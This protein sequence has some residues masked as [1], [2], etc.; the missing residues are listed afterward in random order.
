M[1]NVL[2]IVHLIL[3]LFLIG[4]VLLQRSEGGALGIG[5]GGGG[6]VGASRGGTTALAKVTWTLAA[7]FIATSLALTIIAAQ[8]GA[9][10]S[11]IDRVDPAADAPAPIAPPAAEDD[12]VPADLRDLLAPAPIPPAEPEGDGADGGVAPLTPPAAQ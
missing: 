4:V 8:D 11:V 6:G 12:D 9:S 7:A 3:A 1:E 10:R 5:G 2:L